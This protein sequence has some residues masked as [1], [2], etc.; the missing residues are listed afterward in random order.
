MFETLF[1]VSIVLLVAAVLSKTMPTDG[2]D[3]GED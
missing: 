1:M 2:G 3:R